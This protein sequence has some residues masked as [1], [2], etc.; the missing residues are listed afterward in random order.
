M[1]SQ[2]RFGYEWDSYSEIDPKYEGQFARWVHP[3]TKAS[4]VGKRVLDVGCGMG[5]NSLWASLWGAAEVVAFDFDKRSVA[6]AT[7]NLKERNAQVHFKSVYEIEWLNEFDIAMSIGVIHH[8]KDPK[9]AIRN[10]ARA[11]RPGGLVVIW[12]YGYEGNEWIVRYVDPIRKN[13]T[14]KLPVAFVHL[15]SYFC[16]IPLWIFVKVFR[17]PGPYLAQ[18]ATFSFRHLHSIVFDQLI[19]DVA[20]YWKREEALALFTDI[21]GMRVDHVT[22][23]N[24][25]SWTVVATKT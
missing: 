18:L 11:V 2:E 19:P 12:V 15:I 25:N 13:I 9:L 10:M 23:T 3:L 17:G 5:R 6:A 21:P 1:S 24:K 22:N 20:N 14:S 16:S 7:R 8:L 4:F